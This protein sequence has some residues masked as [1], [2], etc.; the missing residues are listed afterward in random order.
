MKQTVDWHQ[1]WTRKKPGF[2]EGRVNTYLQRYLAD[3]K[4]KQ[5]DRVFLPL[6]GKAYDILWLAQQGL[7]VVGVEMSGVAL[8]SFFEES[9]LVH[10]TD[11]DEHFTV[12][13]SGNITLYEGDFMDLKS[14][15]MGDCK[16]VY[17]RASIVA[18]EAFNREIYSQKLLSLITPATP[19]LMV[20]L[21]YD[22]SIM[23]GPPFSVEV[24]EVESYFGEQYTIDHLE[25]RDQIDES[26]RWRERGLSSFLETALKLTVRS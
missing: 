26:P 11:Q 21:Q 16:L 15:H 1:H 5:G 7:E 24:S 14:S 3:Y 25:T 17:D 12:Y 18:I 8:R 20:L 10:E 13:R 6:C 23:S 19:M 22:Q 9:E 2:H 4:L